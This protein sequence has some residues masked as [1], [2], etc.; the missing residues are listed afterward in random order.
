M[1]VQAPIAERPL[2]K[3]ATGHLLGITHR[4]LKNQ[5]LAH[6]SGLNWSKSRTSA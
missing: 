2:A 6:H 5:A 4:D 1:G 3:D